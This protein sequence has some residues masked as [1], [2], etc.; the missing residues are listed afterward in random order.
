M[1]RANIK[2]TIAANRARKIAPPMAAMS[3]AKIGQKIGQKSM[4]SPPT[5]IPGGMAAPMKKGGKVKKPKVGVAIIV[6]I[7]KKK[8]K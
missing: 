2:Q 1:R 6:A 7:G 3:G 8:A 4:M 5:M